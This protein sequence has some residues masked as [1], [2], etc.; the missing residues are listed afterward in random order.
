MIPG[1]INSTAKANN[2]KQMNGKNPR[3]MS[4]SDML[5]GAT[6]FR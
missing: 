3:K 2:C 1:Q 4:V 5:S 6:D